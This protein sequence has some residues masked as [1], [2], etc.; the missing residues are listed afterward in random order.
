MF[1]PIGILGTINY[2]IWRKISRQN[3]DIINRRN[4]LAE[5]EEEQR[6]IRRNRAELLQTYDADMDAMEGPIRTLPTEA[7]WTKCPSGGCEVLKKD[8]RSNMHCR[9]CSNNEE[10]FEDIVFKQAFEKWSKSETE[11]READEDSFTGKIVINGMYLKPCSVS[12]LKRFH[13]MRSKAYIEDEWNSIP[14]NEGGKRKMQFDWFRMLG[15]P[16]WLA[17]NMAL[18]GIDPGKTKPLKPIT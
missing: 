7:T 13:D 14:L 15:Y 11:M 9:S 4:L 8:Y 16:D 18:Q 12:D 10:Y 3:Q 17:Y 6:F 1:L 2:F 5:M